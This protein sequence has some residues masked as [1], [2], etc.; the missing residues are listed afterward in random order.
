MLLLLSV[1]LIK[2]ILKQ[3]KGVF[4]VKNL[5]TNNVDDSCSFNIICPV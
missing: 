5:Q 3:T 4:Y 1:F 2:K